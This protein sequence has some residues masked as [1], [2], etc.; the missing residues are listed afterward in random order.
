VIGGSLLLSR[1]FS[2]FT[3]TDIAL[4]YLQ[5]D[6][7][8]YSFNSYYYNYYYPTIV[9]K[10]E[11]EDVR[12]FT[13]STELVNDTTLWGYTGPVTGKRYKINVE[14]APPFEQTD[15]SFTT[16]EVDYR[17]Y[18]R[19]G[20]NFTFM[21]RLSGGASLGDD[22]RMFFLGGTD[23]WINARIAKT[24]EGMETLQDIFFARYP[25]PLRGFRYY[26][27]YGRRYFLTNFEFRYP[28]ID[29]L[30]FHW[31]LPL[32]L[33][34][35]S[36]ALFTDIGA[37]WDRPMLD[38]DGGVV[39]TSGGDVVYDHSF[40]GSNSNGGNFRLDD[41]KMSFGFGIRINLGF[42]V[43]RFDTA[44]RTDLDQVD[45]KPMFNFSLGPEF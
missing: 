25:F 36:G 16:L 37:A 39:R 7:D 13:V 3:R 9:E 32:V 33:G 12:T 40:Q 15:I 34:N 22:P 14:Y 44:W 26:E 42:A 23:N 10:S 1:P 41:I 31:P 30:A 29:Y 43:A 21:T 11:I 4:N 38:N 6:R 5:L 27:E 2:K 28:F 19:F 18:H 35:I 20:G 45:D 17:K 24:P 8:S